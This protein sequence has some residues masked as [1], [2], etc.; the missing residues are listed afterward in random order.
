MILDG[1]RTAEVIRKKI[2]EEVARQDEEITLAILHIGN[3]QS[4]MI[5]LESK[6]KACAEVGINTK[7]LK[8]PENISQREILNII[9]DL[10]K[11]KTVNAIMVQTPLPKH[12]DTET[13]LNSVDPMK[14]VDGLSIYNQGKLIKDLPCVVPATAQGVITLLKNNNIDISGK[15]VVIVGRSIVVGKPLAMLFL[16][17]NATVTI[18]HSHTTNLKDITKR[19]DILAVAIGKPRFITADMVKKD[20]V[21]VDIGT[22]RVMGKICG[23][24]DFENVQTVASYISPVPKG[25]GPMTTA[26]LLSNVIKCYKNQK[27]NRD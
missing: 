8:L 26:M 7:I 13:I 15:N 25:I 2:A 21:V 6:E 19:A 20:A 27:M 12:I 10:N 23:D 5:Y 14:D 11:D 9:S 17:E 4:S 22:N 3:D 16:K 18:A 1:L 24:V